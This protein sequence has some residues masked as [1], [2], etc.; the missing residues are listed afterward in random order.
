MAESIA[1]GS[2]ICWTT[3]GKQVMHMSDF[4]IL[5]IVLVVIGLLISAYKL[6]KTNR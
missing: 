6:G 5:S 1:R 2:I 4:E 3:K